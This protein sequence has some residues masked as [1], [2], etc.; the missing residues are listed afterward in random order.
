V[1]GAFTIDGLGGWFVDRIEG[2]AGT[3]IGVSLPV[4][5]RLLGEVGSRGDR[6]VG[7]WTTVDYVSLKSIGLS[8]DL[9]A[10]LVA[11]NPPPTLSS[12]S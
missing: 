9:H 11:H 5:R 6:P 10:Y 1:A 8:D 7:G 3:V 12:P 2:D 4:L